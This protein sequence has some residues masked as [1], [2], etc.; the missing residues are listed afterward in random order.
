MVGVE[1]VGIPI[2]VVLHEEM[3]RLGLRREIG[4]VAVPERGRRLSGGHQAQHGNGE[5]GD[6]EASTAQA[7]Q[8]DFSRCRNYSDDREHTT[9]ALGRSARDRDE[10]ENATGAFETGGAVLEASEVKGQGA[11]A[12]DAERVGVDGRRRNVRMHHA[13]PRCRGRL[14]LGGDD[15]EGDRGESKGVEEN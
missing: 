4:A 12:L 13:E 5:G 6:D 1:A 15:A 3:L 9:P 11:V 7:I 2:G 14:R 8:L 10:D